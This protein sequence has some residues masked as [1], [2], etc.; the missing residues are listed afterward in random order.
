MHQTYKLREKIKL[1]FILFIPILIT[2]VGLYSMN[3]FDTIMSGRA[4]AI[5]LAGVAIASSLWVP[6]FTGMNGVLLAI[7]PIIAQLSGAGEEKKI[8]MKVKQAIYLSIALATLVCLVG[9]ILLEPVLKIMDLEY[10]VYHIA[11]YYLLALGTGIIPL[12]IFNTLRS[13][14]DALGKT[15][16]SMA[17]ILASLPI[18]VLLNYIFIFGKWG[19]PAFGGIGSGIATAIT[20]WIEFFFLCI[21]IQ[22]IEPFKTLHIFT[23]WIK[24]S[25]IA[26]WEQLKIGVP[27]GIATFFETSIFS[28][29][30]LLMSVY[31]TYTIAA[32]QA[33]MNFSSLLYMIP[34]SVGM[35]L[36]IAVGYEVGAQRLKDA[37]SY[38]YL[39]IGN[40]IFIAIFASLILIIFNKPIAALY[41]NNPDVIALTT[42]FIYFAIFLQLA[43]A[44]GAPIQGILRGYKDV[45][46]TLI[47][48][49]VSFWVIGLPSGWFLA[50][51]TSLAPFGY[52]V[53]LIIGLSVGAIALF[54]RLFY[55]QRKEAHKLSEKKS[56][57]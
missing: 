31:S 52:W 33:A 51:Y 38:S 17:I 24:P 42:K 14:V 56:I 37:K 46:V 10:E 30:T 34:L 45:N 55:I 27:I 11:K 48:S 20:Y 28:A 9:L 21:V 54:F 47:L 41:N 1:F 4:G 3:V 49:L 15:R 8:S 23:H 43:D 57:Q 35:T 16:V 40:G 13:F 18:N 36:T 50:N 19:V 39:G 12:F 29:V 5:D 25:I 26:W 22:K 2:Q 7:T 53:G 32:H 44:F 6:I